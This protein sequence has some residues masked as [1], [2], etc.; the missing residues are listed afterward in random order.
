MTGKSK[1]LAKALITR[2]LEE[3]RDTPH[4]AGRLLDS[5]ALPLAILELSIQVADVA[6]AV[7]Q[8]QSHIAELTALAHR[9]EDRSEEQRP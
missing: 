5:E 8:L 3:V 4:A 2:W 9:N 6:K 1:D 7:G